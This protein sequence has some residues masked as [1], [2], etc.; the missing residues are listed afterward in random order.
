MALDP[1]RHR[2][3]PERRESFLLTV[4]A[5]VPYKRFE[6]AIAAAERLGRPLVLVVEDDPELLLPLKHQLPIRLVADVE[7]ALVLVRPLQRHMVRGVC[8]TR[9]E[10]HEERLV[11]G[12][13]DVVAHEAVGVIEELGPSLDEGTNGRFVEAIRRYLLEL[14]ETVQT[15]APVVYVSGASVASNFTL[16]DVN[17]DEDNS[18]VTLDFSLIS[19]IDDTVLVGNGSDE[20]LTMLMRAIVGIDDIVAVDDLPGAASQCRHARGNRREIPRGARFR[21]RRFFLAQRANEISGND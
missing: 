12:E 20:L 11:R 6:W 5:L 21:L 10:V 17:W 18:F 13:G 8:R 2:P 14:P 9:R 7:P 16:G 1:A 19:D 15:L 4:G 3:G